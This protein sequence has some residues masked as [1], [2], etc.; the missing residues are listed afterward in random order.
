MSPE[1]S[2][3][4]LRATGN[5]AVQ[6]ST[7]AQARAAVWAIES[8]GM[9]VWFCPGGSWDIGAYAVPMSGNTDYAASPREPRLRNRG[10]KIALRIDGDIITFNSRRSSLTIIGRS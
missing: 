3:A 10:G 9:T 5:V 4:I 1:T 7:L 6:V 8:L 2:T